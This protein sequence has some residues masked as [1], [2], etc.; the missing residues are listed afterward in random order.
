VLRW[1]AATDVGRVRRV[2]EDAVLAASPLFVV[3][4]GM[5]G[6]AAGEVASSLALDTLRE[7]LG[8]KAQPSLDVV[9]TA[10]RAANLAVF[11]KAAEQAN[12]RGMGTTLCGLV[13]A[14]DG[15]RLVIVNV[16]DSRAYVLQDG[17]LVQITRDHSYVE[18]LVA[19]GE[20]TR[21]EARTHPHR[22]IVTRALGIEPTVD[23]D[24]WQVAL[25]P[26]DRYLLCSDGLFGEV[27][28]DVLAQV[29]TN[30]TDPQEAADRLVR[31]ANEQG[32]R[33]N[34]S[35]VVVDVLAPGP[36]LEPPAATAHAPA[37]VEPA[38]APPPSTPS[39]PSATARRRRV[40][41]SSVLF[42]L[43]VLAVIGVAIGAVQHYGG[44]GYYVAFGSDGRLEVY[45]GRQGGLLWVSPTR[46]GALPLS[47]DKLTPAWQARIADGI[48]FTS[49]DAVDKWFGALSRNPT[50][51]AATAST[52][53][54]TTTTT[55]VATSTPAP[56]TTVGP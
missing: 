24:A 37:P 41:V 16:G 15:D 42:A 39:T 28:E 18:E 50:A 33:D 29:L 34:I 14:G 36:A 55:T 44:E 8:G 13:L 51:L 52:T 5:G 10:V 49:R 56:S 25:T 4:D 3:A 11:N 31:L 23:V 45:K 46:A 30:V 7:T 32:G 40:R 38:A 54:T 9:V 17:A 43:A 47:R 19:A 27:D 21:D 12:L 53:T 48:T 35:A 26:G 6:H 20:L 1:A 22:N 2:N